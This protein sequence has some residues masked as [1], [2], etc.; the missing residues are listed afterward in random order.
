MTFEELAVMIAV[1]LDDAKLQYMFT[2][3]LAV[4]FYGKPGTAHDL[5]IVIL[6]T[7]R[8]VRPL[9]QLFGQDF[10]VLEGSIRTALR[11]VSVFTAI[12]KESG[13]KVNFW[14]RRNDDYSRDAF[15]RRTE[16]TCGPT[17][18]SLVSAEDTIVTRLELYEQ[19][20]ISQHF[21]DAQGIYRIQRETLCV[22]YITNW[23]EGT[24]LAELW[25]R[26]QGE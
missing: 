3:A 19:T 21:S 9:A 8:D 4:N 6:I 20:G 18:I 16:V 14:M 17:R 1:R 11:E 10:C 24:S 7:A 25:E 5:D 22:E 12:H 26:V 15:E 13:M 23:C 2:G